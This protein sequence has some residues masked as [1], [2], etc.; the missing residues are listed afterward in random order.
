MSSSGSRAATTPYAGGVSDPSATSCAARAVP[1]AK[2]CTP[3]HREQRCRAPGPPTGP[4]RGMPPCKGLGH[5]HTQ[6]LGA[7]RQRRAGAVH[8]LPSDQQ[9]ED[10]VADGR[11]R[12][13]DD[14]SGVGGEDAQGQDSDDHPISSETIRPESWTA[15]SHRPS[16]GDPDAQSR[17]CQP[18]RQRPTRAAAA[19]HPVW[20]GGHENRRS[21]ST[22]W[23]SQWRE[24][25]RTTVS[26][27]RKNR[28][29]GGSGAERLGAPQRAEQEQH[30]IWTAFPS[31]WRSLHQ[32]EGL[33]A[34]IPCQKQRWQQPPA[35]RGEQSVVEPCRKNGR[36]E[37]WWRGESGLPLAVARSGGPVGEAHLS[38][39]W[40]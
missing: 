12:R 7:C 36:G 14:A 23:S 37:G 33:L 18:S 31:R 35:G 39:T 9:A 29:G 1:P 6:A 26:A 3:R 8:L 24:R 2:T 10:T 30:T 38:V 13:P 11:A 5:Q 21:A 17:S 28:R 16:N 4:R 15:P 22:E 19:S 25:D 32:W 20:S 27:R 34:E 40:L